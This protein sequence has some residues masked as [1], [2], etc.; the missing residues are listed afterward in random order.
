MNPKIA[1][2]LDTD[3][4]SVTRFKIKSAEWVANE[5][6]KCDVCGK[7]LSCRGE[8]AVIFGSTRSSRNAVMLINLCSSVCLTG[9]YSTRALNLHLS[10][11]DH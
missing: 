7:V 1:R 6:F 11:S 10:G 2:K 8:E 5:K 9:S 4:N 3:D